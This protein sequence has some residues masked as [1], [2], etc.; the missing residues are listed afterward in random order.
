MKNWIDIGG[1][2]EGSCLWT[3]DALIAF[4]LG[5]LIGIKIYLLYL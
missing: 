4:S 1:P 5:I 3:I 2:Y